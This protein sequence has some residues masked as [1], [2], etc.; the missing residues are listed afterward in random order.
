MIK[1]IQY[2][3]KS[4]LGMKQ[5]LKITSNLNLEGLSHQNFFKFVV[6]QYLQYYAPFLLLTKYV[7]VYHRLRAEKLRFFEVQLR[8]LRKLKMPIS[9]A[10]KSNWHHLLL[11]K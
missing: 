5:C 4:S 2:H 11:Q 10:I 6:G 8:I 7:L 3:Y 1:S 9:M